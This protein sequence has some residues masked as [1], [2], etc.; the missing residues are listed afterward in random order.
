[1]KFPYTKFR[2]HLSPQYAVTV[3][4]PIVPIGIRYRGRALP[5][6]YSALIDSGADDCL[7]HAEVGEAIGIEVK[8]GPV[9]TYGGIGFGELI[10]HIHTVEIQ[11]GGYWVE[12]QAAFAYGMLRDHPS[13]PGM[14]QGLRYGVLGQ[15]GFFDKFKVIFDFAAEEIELRPKSSTTLTAN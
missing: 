2:D 13:L 1:M 10:G 5:A 6:L 12:C 8:N 3:L 11:V 7:F 14:R 9:K 4:R 15:A